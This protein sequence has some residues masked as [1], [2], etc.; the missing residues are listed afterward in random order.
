MNGVYLVLVIIYVLLAIPFK[1]YSQPFIVMSAIPFGI[2][3]ALLGHLIMNWILLDIMGRSVSPSASVTMLSLLGMLALSGVVVNDSLVMVDFI[4]RQVK[5]G[6]P[7]GEAIRLAGI[8]RFRPILLTSLTTFV[9]LLPLMFDSS[10][11][12]QFLIPMAI[13]LGWG[14]I[15]ATFITLLLVP[16]ITLI[17]NDVKVAFC[18]LY[19]MKPHAEPAHEEKD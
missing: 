12:A 11:Q 5:S 18:E 3:G 13:S 7:L 10:S 1:S 16:I 8:R 19:D 15:F 6:M 2:I 14:I 17:F 9:G 4:N